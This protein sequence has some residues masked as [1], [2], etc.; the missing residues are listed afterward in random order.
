MAEA[1]LGEVRLVGFNFAPQGWALCDG[2]LLSIAQNNALFALLGT[3]FGGDGVSTFALPDL[4]GRVPVHQGQGSGL[5]P[6]NP[7]QTGGA[8]TV[9]LVTTQMPAHSHSV[10]ANSNPGG[11]GSPIGNFTAAIPDPNSGAPFNA[12]ATSANGAMNAGVLGV[13]GGSQPHPNL[14]PYLCANFI[15]A[16]QGIFPSRS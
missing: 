2:Q 13:T 8:E 16:L 9:A 6:Y 14:Q 10:A 11:A 12:F 3:T 4:R 1:F 7:G 5:S 15:I